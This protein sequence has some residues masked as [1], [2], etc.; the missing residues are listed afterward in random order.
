MHR[1]YSY[2]R[3]NTDVEWI[4]TL[5]Q[6]DTVFPSYHPYSISADLPV[7]HYPGI[8]AVPFAVACHRTP[9]R[10]RTDPVYHSGNR[11]EK[12]RGPLEFPVEHGLSVAAAVHLTAPAAALLPAVITGRTRAAISALWARL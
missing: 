12:L 11:A 1:P 5:S 2:E 6:R 8:L 10:C 7:G 4:S 3:A 9:A